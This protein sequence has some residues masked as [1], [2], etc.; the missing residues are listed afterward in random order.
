MWLKSPFCPILA[1]GILNGKRNGRWWW[2]VS[3]LRAL[4][5]HVKINVDISDS[6]PASDGASYSPHSNCP[7]TPDSSNKWIISK[8]VNMLKNMN[9]YR[10]LLSIEHLELYLTTNLCRN[11]QK[12][13]CWHCPGPDHIRTNIIMTFSLNRFISVDFYTKFFL[14]PGNKEQQFEIPLIHSS[15]V[16]LP[17]LPRPVLPVSLVQVERGHAHIVPAGLQVLLSVHV[18]DHL[19]LLHTVV[20]ENDDVMMM[21]GGCLTVYSESSF[22]LLIFLSFLT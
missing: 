18:L 16:Q 19:H 9:L 11:L 2:L 14:H 21:N 1:V 3:W 20:L 10:L 4:L 22:F 17:P 6:P 8:K 5:C 15:P 12:K 7:S 13:K